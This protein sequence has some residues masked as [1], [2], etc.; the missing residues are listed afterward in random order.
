MIQV[1]WLGDAFAPLNFREI[2]GGFFVMKLN[3]KFARLLMAAAIAASLMSVPAYALEYNFTNEQPGQQFY[4]ATTAGQDAAADSDTIIVGADGTIGT[5]ASQVPNSSPLSVLDLAVGEYPDAWGSATD[6]AIAQNTVFPN[7]YA[8][9][10][11][12]SNVPGFVAF[13]TTQVSS[14]ALPTGSEVLASIY[15]SAR[16]NATAIH[17]MPTITKGGAI[18][19]LQ[20]PSIGLNYY[21]YDGTSTYNMRRGLAHFDCTSGWMGN[22][23]LAG[24]NR[25]SYAHFAKLKDVQYGDTVMY[26]TAYGTATYRVTSISHCATTDTSGLLQ[27]G[28]NKITMY[29][30]KAG[31]PSMK[32]CV[33]ATLVG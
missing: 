9:T 31:D 18:G 27:D 16:T 11:Q 6:I 3:C 26:T 33:V 21:A 25:G 17:A 20:I 19:K 8:P 12:W 24:H 10:T 30:C 2:K 32:L 28:T 13:D 29:T 5:D 15:A 1:N 7:A 14:G 23:A 22:I 4:Q